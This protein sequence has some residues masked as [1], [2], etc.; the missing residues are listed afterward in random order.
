MKFTPDNKIT[1]EKSNIVILAVKPK[2]IPFVLD[3]LYSYVNK[4]HLIVTFAA[5][6]N[7]SS[8]EKVSIYIW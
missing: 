4:D 5:G 2:I 8:I 6:V 7:I 3:D 1:L